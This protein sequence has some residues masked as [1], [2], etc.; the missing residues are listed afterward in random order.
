[1]SDSTASA[2]AKGYINNWDDEYTDDGGYIVE[3]VRGHWNCTRHTAMNYY[4]AG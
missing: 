2:P 4:P 1:M 3:C